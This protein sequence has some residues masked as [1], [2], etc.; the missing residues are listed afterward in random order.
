MRKLVGRML[1]L[2]LVGGGAG[3]GA[4]ADAWASC[5]ESYFTCLN[6]AYAESYW[7]ARELMNVECG[8]RY[9]GCLARALA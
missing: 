2:S 9:Y 4:P 6:D 7:L 3:L 8:I 1:M 5:T